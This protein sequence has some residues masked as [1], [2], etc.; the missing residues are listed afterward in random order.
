M[1]MKKTYTLLLA[2]LTIL[3]FAG[4]QKTPEKEVVVQKDMEQM[5]E[6]AQVTPEISGNKLKQKLDVPERF[7]ANE[8]YSDGRL[9]LAAEANIVLPDVG[10]LPVVRVE[11]ENFSQE[12]VDK[13]YGSLIGDTPMYEQQ[14]KYTKE[15]IQQDILMW[16]KILSDPKSEDMS[17]RQAEQEISKLEETYKTAPEAEDMVP[18]G[19]EI[20]TQAE[21]DP[22]T[23]EKNLEYSGVNIA[24]KP[25]YFVQTGK[26]FSVRN[27]T[28]DGKIVVEEDEFGASV[29]DTASQGARF[30]YFDYDLAPSGVECAAE[31]VT[32]EN[33]TDRP[34]KVGG[35][36]YKQAL[37][38]AQDFLNKTGIKDMEISSLTLKYMLPDKYLSLVTGTPA[39]HMTFTDDVAAGKYDSE[40]INIFI[41][42]DVARIVNGIQV[43][44]NGS[45]SYIGDAM[46]GA[47]WFYED[48]TIGVCSKG[49]YSVSWVSPHSITDTVTEDANMLPFNEITDVFDK[50]YR[51]R[52]DASG[53]NLA[54]EV[55][56]VVL[57]LR[58]V[59][60]QNNIGYGLFVPVWDFYGTMT[61]SYPDD[62]DE[63]PQEWLSGKPLLTI[64]AI[65]GTVIDLDE[66]Y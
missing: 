6:K 27:N 25:G 8:S 11:P 18:A 4:C 20:K 36:S 13:L 43:T 54:G 2:V 5:I 66:G 44:S 62:P 35:F 57:S 16:K 1:R 58:R 19:S 50:M 24:Q 56:R 22:R 46:Y 26:T 23:G 28:R 45:S 38:I 30:Y 55:E 48:F 7:V 61:V 39:E 47:Q 42:I 33:L 64:N 9:T 60:D 31:T 17:K 52:Y 32:P 65:D 12:L 21:Y 40:V 14:Q 53:N 59:M 3:I 10:A 15:Q 49:I 34:E 37:D 63:P 29:T 51:V 41:D